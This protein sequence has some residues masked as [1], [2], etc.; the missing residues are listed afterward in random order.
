MKNYNQAPLP[1]QGQKR[2]FLKELKQELQQFS[3]TA[4]YVDLFGGSGF[5]S[6]TVK[7]HYPKATVVY[8]D[9]DN[10]TYRLE[11]VEKTNAIIADIREILAPIFSTIMKFPE[12]VQVLEQVFIGMKK[13]D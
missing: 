12:R 2:R 9:F 3:P 1:F 7:Q 8:N 4:T 11:S 10:Y 6:H 13:E 5:L